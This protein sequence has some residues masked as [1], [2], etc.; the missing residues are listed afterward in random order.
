MYL[1]G[2]CVHVHDSFANAV[3]PG[4]REAAQLVW[5]LFLVSL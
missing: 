5:L 3:Q 1:Y 2:V 4:Q